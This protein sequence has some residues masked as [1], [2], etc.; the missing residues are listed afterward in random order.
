MIRVWRLAS[1]RC[2]GGRSAILLPSLLVLLV[3][4]ISRPGPAE[5]A[6]RGND[7]RTLS[8]VSAAFLKQV[9]TARASIPE[10]VWR[11]IRR[12][13]WRVRLVRFVTDAAPYL[14]GVHP[15]GWPRNT[16]W[17]HT[18]AAHLPS[19]R[20]VVVAEKRRTTKG[21]VVPGRRVAGVLRHEL[22]HAF[23][24]AYSGR[25]RYCSSRPS[26][27]KAYWGDVRQM[28]SSDRATLKYYLQRSP[29]GPQE[30]FA[31]A[32]GI[33][34]GGGSDPPHQEAIERA[35]PRVLRYLRERL[36]VH[37]RTPQPAVLQ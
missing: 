31:E 37:R 10:P 13:G 20:L 33:V 11:G 7:I 9:E 19:R 34:L 4:S 30:A 22:G 27:R 28:S 16:T 6:R 35:F 5:N 29:A 25:Y 1:L 8:P 2:R 23:D 32:F 17:D 24:V 36:A 21:K 12:Y 18:D 3:V 15:R 14:R 26:F